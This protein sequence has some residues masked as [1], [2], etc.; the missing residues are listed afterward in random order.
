MLTA[1]LQHAETWSALLEESSMK[2]DH[3]NTVASPVRS[4]VSHY[5]TNPLHQPRLNKWVYEWAAAN[6]RTLSQLHVLEKTDMHQN[7]RD[8]TAWW[9]VTSYISSQHLWH[10]VW[11]PGSRVCSVI[12]EVQLQG[13]SCNLQHLK[14]KPY[15]QR[16][17]LDNPF[18]YI[19]A[20]CVCFCSP[21]RTGFP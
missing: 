6:Y 8:S 4:R 12:L 13:L 5:Y 11:H 14:L 10:H 19:S 15:R 1:R 3:A 9:Q 20:C 16:P 21:S 7:D 17:G 18:Y 2:H